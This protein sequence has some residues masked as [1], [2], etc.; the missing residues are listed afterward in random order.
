MSP[1]IRDIAEAAGVSTAAVSYV[2]NDKP[3]V[4]EETRRRVLKIMREMNYRPNP[5]AR[6]L[7]A[8]RTGMIGLMI[9][10]I[11]DPFYVNI[12]RGVEAKANELGYTLNLCTTHGDAERERDVAELFASGGVDGVIMMT[13]KLTPSELKE[14]SEGRAPVVAIDN[15]EAAGW[16]PSVLVDNIA[17]G[18]TATSYLTELGHT[19]IGFI[20]GV[21][22]S[23]ASMRRYEG[24][25]QALKSQGAE[26]SP[27]LVEY[28]GFTHAG[29]VEA[30]RVLL[31]RPQRPTAIF[32]A[33]D[34]MALGAMSAA[35][36]LGLSVPS[37]LSIIG[38]DDIE[39]AALVV[40]GLTTLKQPTCEI[41]ACAVGILA[42][43]IRSPE[44]DDE[45]GASDVGQRVF[46]AR[47]IVRGSCAPRQ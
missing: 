34:Q 8:R 26:F 35:M 31:S 45:A 2:L 44:G 14:L 15:P 17:L 47:L 38:V 23:I 7:A 24:Y 13:Y 37:D 22:G 27:E 42:D 9:P 16:V 36:E 43:L 28:G 29:G 33:N 5:Q 25:V 39:A 40:P 32:A 41:G 46:E 1:T 12:V 11:T 20:H 6:G 4:G 18:R 19:R 30:A 10:D 3:G 21:E